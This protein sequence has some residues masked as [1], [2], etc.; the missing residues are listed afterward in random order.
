MNWYKIATYDIEFFNDRNI[1]ND[2]IKF[3][4]KIVECLQ[5]I[6]KIVFQSSRVAREV[7]KKILNH[8]KISSYPKIKDVLQEADK[9]ALDSPW[10]FAAF[11]KIAIDEI[12]RRVIGLEDDRGHYIDKKLPAKMKGF[13]EHGK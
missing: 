5:D 7:N 10:R 11:C 3:F 12:D 8:K 6:S 13:F 2:K 9:A 4:K 1:V